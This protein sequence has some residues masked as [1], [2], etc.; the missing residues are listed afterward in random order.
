MDLKRGAVLLSSIQGLAI[1][2]DPVLYT[3]LIYQP[4]KRASRHIQQ[5]SV[6][7]V[8][9]GVSVTR[10]KEDEASVGSAPLARQQSNQA[11]EYASSPVKT[12]TVTESRPLSLPVKTMLNSSESCRSPE[13]RM[14]EFIGIV[15]N[16]VK[17]LTLQLEV[18]SCCVFLPNDSLPSPSTIVSGDIPGTVRSWYHGQASMPGIL[19]V[20][21]PQIKI[22]SAGHKH[23]EPLQEIPFVV[24]RPILEEGD[25]FPWT[26][27]LHHFSVYTLLGQQMT[28]NLVEPMGC[29]STLAVTSQKLLASG[30]ESRH[31]FVVCLHV[32]LE[33]LEIKCSNP[34]VQLLYELAEITSKVWN[35][36]QRKGMLYQ[37]SIY[38]ETVTGPVPPS[39]PVKSSVG[40]APP[41]TSTYSPSADVGT[42]TELEILKSVEQKYFAAIEVCVVS[43]LEDLSASVDMQDVYTKIKC[44]IESFNIDHYRNRYYGKIER[45]YFIPGP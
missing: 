3:W 5:Q 9:L 30:P 39:S 10:K 6:G 1:N 4:Q 22:M 37:S 34:Q 23:M 2:V 21:L 14:K 45:K 38:T 31:S 18:Q 41:D 33:S 36:I 40:T 19:V 29:T 28:L 43:E 44:K 26:I 8:P 7:T 17:R 12:K 24:L 25:A 32:D 20:C 15:W 27:S 16:A 11:S 13:E 35:K 42:T